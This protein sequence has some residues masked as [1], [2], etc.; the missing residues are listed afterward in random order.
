MEAALQSLGGCTGL[1][2]GFYGAV[3][4]SYGAAGGTGDI[5]MHSS[6]ASVNL[7]GGEADAAAVSL[8]ASHPDGGVTIQAATDAAGSVTV[9]SGT[10]GTSVM[11]T[12]TVSVASSQA[13]GAAVHAHSPEVIVL[14]PL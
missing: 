8:E 3:V 7:Q 1:V 5:T 11:S 6:L 13:S 14:C 2:G 9:A 10:S 12:G 4:T